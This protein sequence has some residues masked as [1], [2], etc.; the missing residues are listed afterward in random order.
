MGKGL[1][2]PNNSVEVF[3]SSH[4]IEHLDRVEADNF[5]QEALRVL[6]P[7]GIIRIVVPDLNYLVNQYLKTNDADLFIE[8]TFLSQPK[9]KTL[10]DKFKKIVVGERHH[11]WMYDELSLCRLFALVRS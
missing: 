5:L 11:H 6:Q 4:M 3:Y 2:I 10:L 9:P 8:S 1:P 7:N